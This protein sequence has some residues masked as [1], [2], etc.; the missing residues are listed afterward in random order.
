MA[1]KHRKVW[2]VIFRKPLS[3]KQ[4]QPE[5]AVETKQS[6]LDR[7]E[8]EWDLTRFVHTPPWTGLR[9]KERSAV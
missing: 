1:N 7:R 5:I 2:K 8:M 6:H 3:G 4:T 9:N